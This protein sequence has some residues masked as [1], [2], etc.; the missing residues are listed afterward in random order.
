VTVFNA[1]QQ[2]I[3]AGFTDI[4]PEELPP[5]DSVPYQ[6]LVP[7]SGGTPVNYI[8]NVQGLGKPAETPSR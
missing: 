8:V 4:I 7:E 5:G 6:I 1:D 3:A 2:V